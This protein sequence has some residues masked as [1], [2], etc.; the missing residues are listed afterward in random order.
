MVL[1]ILLHVHLNRHN[2][3]LIRLINTPGV[4]N[5][6]RTITNTNVHIHRTPYTRTT[7]V[8][9]SRHIRV[10]S[11]SQTLTIPRLTRMV[12]TQPTILH[13]RA[14]PTRRRI[15]NKLSR[16]L[17]LRRAL[18]V[19]HVQQTTSRPFRSQLINL[20]RLRRR[21][22]IGPPSNRGQRP[23]TNSS[24]TSTRSLTYNIVMPMAIRRMAPIL[25]RTLP[26]TIVRYIRPLPRRP[27][28]HVILRLTSQRRLQ[29]LQ[30]R[31]RPLLTTIGVNRL[32]NHV[33]KVARQHTRHNI[34]RHTITLTIRHTFMVIRHHLR[35]RVI[36][37][38]IRRIRLQ[39]LT[40]VITMQIRT[41][42]SHITPILL[43]STIHPPTSLRKRHRPLRIPFPQSH[44][45]LIRIISIRRRPI[46]KKTRRT[47][48][49]SVHITSHLSKSTNNQHIHRIIHRSRHNT[50]MRHRHKVTR[51]MMPRQSRVQRPL[52]QLF[53]R[54]PSRITPTQRSL[55]INITLR[56]YNLTRHSTN[57]NLPRQHINRIP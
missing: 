56:Q 3:H 30:T 43:L 33:I 17:P 14:H 7:R 40:S 1:L 50:T 57:L 47:R 53:L 42:Y 48:V 28:V 35:I 23:N 24:Q 25:M 10:V 37:P 54:G 19:H 45:Y 6:N 52:H 34:T 38:S 15:N 20:L 36:M 51:T 27:R 26:M 49:T 41:T 16:L 13:R 18:T 29:Q 32:H 12:I 21:Q 9:R 44:N 55:P 22:I 46:T 5:S 31:P 11:I 4:I 8:Q 39:R 2:C